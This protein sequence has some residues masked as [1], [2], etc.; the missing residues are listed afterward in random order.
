MAYTIT[1][2]ESEM[3]TLGWMAARW[4]APSNLFESMNA[5]TEHENG[6]VTYTIRE[7]DAWAINEIAF[8]PDSGFVCLNWSS[9]LGAKILNFLESIV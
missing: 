6:S 8:D 4:E 1:L 3:K 5:E 9:S 2:T 7:S